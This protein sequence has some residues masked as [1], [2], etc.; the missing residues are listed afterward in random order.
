MRDPAA[1]QRR[2]APLLAPLALAYGQA[3][4]WRRRLYASG[5]LSRCA[6][7]LPC[8]SVGNIAAGGGGKTPLALWLLQQSLE[9]GIR[10]ALLSRGYGGRPPQRPL[11]VLPDTPWQHSGDEP[12]LLAREA[13]QA[14]VLADP[15]RCRAAERARDL[16]AQL[17]VMDDGMQH[18]RLPRDLNL[19]L[20]RPRDLLDHWGR[21]LPLGLWREPASALA[22]ADAF[23]LKTPEA[24][25]PKLRQAMERRL[26]H[27]QKPVFTFSLEPAG[28]VRLADG[29]PLAPGALRS[30]VFMSALAD[31]AQA[32][33]TARAFLGEPATRRGFPDHKSLDAGDLDAMEQL[34]RRHGADWIVCTAKDAVKLPPGAAQRFCVLQTRLRFRENLFTAQDFP[35]WWRARLA[36]LTSQGH[37]I[38]TPE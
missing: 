9:A 20:L 33:A 6:S 10:P 24:L 17:L 38:S 2:L 22:C 14:L 37:N 30:Y 7:G 8:V 23:L 16:G 27:L 5:V 21:V 28:L 12:L 3:M 26:A 35:Q 19:V 15:D 36:S 13:P 32:A 25:Q 34:R 31:N 1:W 18:L 11:R 4:L 29:A